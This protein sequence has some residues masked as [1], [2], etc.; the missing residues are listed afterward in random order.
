MIDGKKMTRRICPD[1]RPEV[2]Q[3][4]ASTRYGKQ[5]ETSTAD[6]TDQMTSRLFPLIIMS[7]LSLGIN[8]DT[9]DTILTLNTDHSTNSELPSPIQEC[10]DDMH[11]V[12]RLL[13][14]FIYIYS[15]M[16]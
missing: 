11:N 12:I 6:S 10:K 3:W 16:S 7:P 2:G 8:P 1:D 14:C 5:V 13:E 4:S 15:L 9:G